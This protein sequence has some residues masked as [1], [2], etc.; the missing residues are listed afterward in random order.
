MT[1][2][3]TI[4]LLADEGWFGGAVA[5]GLFMPMGGSAHHRDLAT[6]AGHFWDH[7]GG[8]NQ[9]APVLVSTKGRYVWCD[10]P[11]RFLFGPDRTLTLIGD[12]IVIEQAGDDL[13]GAYRAAQAAH[14]PPSGRCVDELM[15]TAPQYNTWIEAPYVPTQGKVLDYAHGV[16]E[17][18]LPPGVIMID[19]LWAPDY[20]TWEFE[21]TQFPDPGAMCRELHEMGFKVMLWVVPYLSPDSPT[22]R[23]LAREGLLITRPDGELSL[24]HWWNG[25]SSVLDLTNPATLD[26]VR[27][28]FAALRGLGVDGFKLDA[29]DLRYYSD[30]EVTHGG[31]GAVAQCEAWARLGSEY[32]LNEMRACW[33]LGGQPLA[34]RL[35]D[36]PRAWG[37]MGIESLIP[38]GIAQGLIGHA[39]NCPDMIGGGELGSFEQ[40]GEIDQELFVRFAQCSA[41]FPMMQFSLVPWR[42]LDDEHLASVTEVVAIRQGLV[43]EISAL[44]AHAARTG[45]PILRPL[46]FHHPDLGHVTDQ[47]LLGE[48]LLVAPVL[49]RGA[50]ERT[51]VVPSGRWRNEESGDQIEGPTTVE[52]AVQLRSLPRFR[53]L[54]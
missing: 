32:P 40:G 49:R 52:V 14:F 44:F 41:L 5:D 13:A 10:Q 9:S 45:D 20:G 37:Q 1:S 16:L 39:F 4:D 27:G 50:T 47:F 31:G 28:K 29:G 2:H 7:M 8:A 22:S 17:H 43:D 6:N 25:W 21:P 46:A 24:H 54:D 15:Y 23:Q 42:V 12:D 26:W 3:T 34:Q 18:G 38:E 33:K 53:R 36:K 51:V 48:N 19:D 30:T 35:H 11:F